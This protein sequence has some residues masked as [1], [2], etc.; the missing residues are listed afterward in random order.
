MKLIKMQ[1][2]NC[3]ADIQ[4]EDKGEQRSYFCNYC[5][6]SFILDDGTTTHVHKEIDVARIREADVK[7]TIELK[8]LE[9]NERKRIDRQRTVIVV[10]A[11]LLAIALVGIVLR[12]VNRHQEEKIAD[13]AETSI[14]ETEKKTTKVKTTEK[15]FIETE[16]ETTLSTESAENGTLVTDSDILADAITP[17]E[18]L[19]Q[20]SNSDVK[21]TKAGFSIQNG[22]MYYTVVLHN[23]SPENIYQL[24]G[25]RYTLRGEDNSIIGTGEQILHSIYPGQDC[26]WAFL[27]CEASR[28]P[29]TVEFSVLDMQDY[30]VVNAETYEE[31]EYEPLEVINV[32]GKADSAFG[33]VIYGE[34]YNPN[35]YGFSQV[36]V[37]VAFKDDNNV[38]LGGDLTFINS[39]P[40]KGTVAFQLTPACV[41]TDHY[42]LFANSWSF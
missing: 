42:E 7:E 6:A 19:I 31:P 34:V 41:T 11:A 21:I 10:L 1:C 2:P 28:M 36:A 40:A 18:V 4:I 25:F 8:K 24:P 15:E 5:G 33:K 27:G 16:S 35:D 22:Y 14:I 39:L 30:N 17:D 20:D 13:V 32:S 9:L 12:F 3:N 38:L 26:A 37:G 29:E 23:N